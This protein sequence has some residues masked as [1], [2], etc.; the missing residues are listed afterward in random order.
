MTEEQER[1]RHSL[2]E[3]RRSADERRGH[4]RRRPPDLRE[5]RG[6]DPARVAGPTLGLHPCERVDHRQAVARRGEPLELVVEHAKTRVQGV[7]VLD[8]VAHNNDRDRDVFQVGSTEVEET[9]HYSRPFGTVT[10]Y[11]AVGCDACNG[12]GYFGRTAVLECLQI[13]QDASRLSG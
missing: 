7:Y 11:R 9:V 2:D 8:M 6:V 5:H 4:G 1:V 10:L 13:V 3:R 12:S